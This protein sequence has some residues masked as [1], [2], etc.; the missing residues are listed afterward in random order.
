V[1]EEKNNKID[2]QPQIKEF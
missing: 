2:Y 1:E